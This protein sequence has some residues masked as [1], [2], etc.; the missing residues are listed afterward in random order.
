MQSV[1]EILQRLPKE[2]YCRRHPLDKNYHKQFLSKEDMCRYV[3]LK[4]YNIKME[5]KRPAFLKFPQTKRPL[6]FDGY[7]P[8]VVTKIGNGI[9]FEYNGPQ[10]YFL[11]YEKKYSKT[12]LN[13]IALYDSLKKKYCL[14]NG[15]ALII[16]P[17]H[18]RKN[19][20]VKFLDEE[21]KKYFDLI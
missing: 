4:R 15:I 6:E 11:N 5:K 19:D 8:N 7:N 12:K 18:I 17:Y 1:F 10:H 3:F 14:D 21:M 9:A 13:K 16:I 20:I 2:Y